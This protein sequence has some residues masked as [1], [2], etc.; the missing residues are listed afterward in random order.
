MPLTVLAVEHDPALRSLY[1]A[2]LAERG[3]RVRVVPSGEEAVRQLDIDIDIVVVDL[4]S[5]QSRGRV[6][7]DAVRA[8]AAY[9]KVPV[10][11]VDGEEGGA[12]TGIE[13]H[14]MTLR[15]PFVFRRFVQAVESLASKPRRRS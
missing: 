9:Q 6:V 15:K 4:R 14:A 12:T 10:L 7:L 13:S 3:H 1:Y 8:R 2:L 5:K 11:I